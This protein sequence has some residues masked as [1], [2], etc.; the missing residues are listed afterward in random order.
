MDLLLRL[1]SG[2][3]KSP[4][5]KQQEDNP[6]LSQSKNQAWEQL[7]FVGDVWPKILLKL[8]QINWFVQAGAADNVLNFEIGKPNFETGA[9]QNINALPACKPRIGLAFPAGADHITG[10]ED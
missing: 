9:L 2:H 7:W 4:R 8:N 1:G 5:S 3:N 6:W 10:P